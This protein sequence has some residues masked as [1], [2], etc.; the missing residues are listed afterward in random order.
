MEIERGSVPISGDYDE[1]FAPPWAKYAVLCGE[2]VAFCER[3]DEAASA[4]REMVASGE[5]PECFRVAS[6]VAAEGLS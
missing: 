4:W 3:L 1:R 6:L 5:K 2:A